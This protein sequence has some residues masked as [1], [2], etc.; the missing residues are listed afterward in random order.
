MIV[1][2][3][4]HIH[5]SN[6][7][8]SPLSKDTFC[9]IYCIILYQNAH[10]VQ[11]YKSIITSHTVQC[12]SH[13]PGWDMKFEAC[14]SY[15]DNDQLLFLC[16]WCPYRIIRLDSDLITAGSC[17]I[18]TCCKSSTRSSSLLELLKARYFHHFSLFSC[19]H[20]CWCSV[21]QHSWSSCCVSDGWLIDVDCSSRHTVRGSP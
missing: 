3:V 11:Y 13:K 10:T 8:N 14:E 6:V 12:G 17:H 5:S 15:N 1:T 2:C 21:D 4:T 16:C 19:F 9:Y 7:Y 20:E 18:T